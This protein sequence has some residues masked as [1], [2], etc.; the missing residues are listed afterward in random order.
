MEGK[1]LGKIRS[2]ILDNKSFHVGF[3]N[4]SPFSYSN[5]YAGD[6]TPP[7]GTALSEDPS[8]WDTGDTDLM[9]AEIGLVGKVADQ[10]YKVGDAFIEKDKKKEC[11]KAQGTWKDGKCV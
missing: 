2:K 3:E 9:N 1:V 5:Q 4:R 10:L 7:V 6:W 11:E 8:Q